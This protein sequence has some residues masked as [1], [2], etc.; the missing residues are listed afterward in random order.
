M[1]EKI[2]RLSL[3]G[4]SPATRGEVGG[5]TWG[6]GRVGAITFHSLRRKLK[7]ASV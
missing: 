5:D 7:R 2:I 3:A 6:W 1:A 4:N